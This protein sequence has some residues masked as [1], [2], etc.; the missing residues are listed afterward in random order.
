MD[1][2]GNVF[3]IN[4]LEFSV[5]DLARLG[6]GEESGQAPTYDSGAT[7]SDAVRFGLG[8]SDGVGSL[9]LELR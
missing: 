5:K 2:L 6:F 9:L 8:K 1:K 4:E 3:G 7:V